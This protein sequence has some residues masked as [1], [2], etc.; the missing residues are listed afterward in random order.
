[1]ATHWFAVSS[2]AGCPHVGLIDLQALLAVYRGQQEHAW[3]Q[4]FVEH[5]EGALEATGRYRW[6]TVRRQCAS[7]TS[8]GTRG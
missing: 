4:V 1:M 8:P 6:W 5:V 2:T 3:S 7:S